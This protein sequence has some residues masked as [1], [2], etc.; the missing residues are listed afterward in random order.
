[1][2]TGLV[3]AVGE[4]RGRTSVG[5]ELR[6]DVDIRGL[7]GTFRLGDSI[8]LSGVCCTVIALCDGIT[9]FHL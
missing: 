7:P 5:Q 1:M 6:L 3:Q 8:A 2:F 4:V 9:S